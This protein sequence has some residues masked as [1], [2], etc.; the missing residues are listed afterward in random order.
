MTD[1]RRLQEMEGLTPMGEE[2]IPYDQTDPMVDVAAPPEAAPQALPEAAPAP[3]G[4][5][6]PVGGGMEPAATGPLGTDPGLMPTTDDLTGNDLAALA[7]PVDVGEPEDLE[8]ERLSAALDDP[9]VP[10]QDKAMIQQ[11]LDLAARRRLAG[12]GGQPQAGGLLA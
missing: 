12:T 4:L 11:M 6:A 5:L 3:G 2:R 8:V 7:D 9:A 1:R 10:E